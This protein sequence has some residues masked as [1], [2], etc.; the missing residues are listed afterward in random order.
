MSATLAPAPTNVLLTDQITYMLT[1]TNASDTAA[2]LNGLPAGF[3]A[4]AGTT[5]FSRVDGP[6]TVP[7]N[8]TSVW[9][10]T[11]DVNDSDADATT[12]TQTP[13]AITYGMSAF[14][15]AGR[16]LAV[17]PTTVSSTVK[18]PVVAVG[19]HS[20]T[21]VNGG[22]LLPG[23][24]VDVSITISNTGTGSTAATLSDALTNLQNP[25]AIKL[26]NVACG[27]C[28]SSA[29]Q[30]TAPL[31]TLAAGGSHVVTFS[32]TVPASP[33]GSNAISSTTVAFSPATTGTSP[34]AA[35]NSSLT[36][37][38]VN[39]QDWQVSVS[40]QPPAS[41][42]VGDIVT[43]KAT[44]AVDPGGQN[45]SVTSLTSGAGTSGLDQIL[46]ADAVPATINAGTAKVLTVSARVTGFPGA[47]GIHLQI[48]VGGTLGASSTTKT[49][50]TGTIASTEA[51]SAALAA[52]PAS[53]L[54]T[55][56]ITYTLT[57]TNSSDTPAQ[58][59]GLPAGLVAPAGSTQANRTDGPTTV[60]ANGTSTWTLVVTVNGADTNGT[61]ITQA[62]G[63]VSY[64]MSAIGLASRALAVMPA[65][66]G[67][68]VSVPPPP[69][70]SPPPR[71]GTPA[72]TT[73]TA[74][75]T[76]ATTTTAGTITT[77]S[78]TTT[79]STTTT[80]P[81][82]STTTTP[83]T[84]TDGSTTV[85]TTT[86]QSPAAAADLALTVVTSPTGL[87]RHQ[88]VYRFTITNNGPAPATG[89]TLS[90][91]LIAGGARL[92][93]G[94]VHCSHL[95]HL[96][97]ALGDLAAGKSAKVT[98]VLLARGPALYENTAAVTA[99][100]SDPSPGNNTLTATTKVVHLQH[101]I[102]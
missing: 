30:V 86:T 62:P 46:F 73:T 19:T 61:V 39:V 94:P 43:V 97:C 60:P 48:A 95:D 35:N 57:L 2:Q 55:D 59:T 26:D 80:S 81:T 27:A 87:A 29:T 12:I 21:D 64:G 49:A 24:V 63:T 72:T 47:G 89:V 96:V 4:P 28:S 77:T 41:A 7:A 22:A 79:P 31:G 84:T 13:G 40:Q 99:N 83:T 25:T 36:I 45:L 53:V 18:A 9:T 23:D 54:L 93:S 14:G 78:S 85:T 92:V 76:T 33:I 6:A 98:I 38:S 56:Q 82:T 91:K 69:A 17:T 75:T 51:V 20:L 32:A 44:I 3:V 11:V 74:T 66:V 34:T 67:S 71:S 5:L 90:T 100:E 70:P 52:V 42:Q 1:V 102:L 65:S 58:L 8:G 15:L 10:L 50:D 101:P 37:G 68:T 88:L 16:P